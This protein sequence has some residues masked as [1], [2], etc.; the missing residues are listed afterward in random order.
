MSHIKSH[1]YEKKEILYLTCSRKTSFTV[2][3]VKQMD[4]R[5]D[6]MITREDVAKRAGVS[7]SAV[8]RTINKRGYVSSDK[9]EKIWKAID[10]LGYTSNALGKMKTKAKTHQI[11]LLFDQDIRNNFCVE[12][13]EYMMHYAAS[14]GEILFMAKGIASEKLISMSIDG[15]IV[16][17]DDVA[18]KIHKVF[19]EKLK[20]PVVSASYGLPTIQT[21]KIPYVDVDSYDAMR[22]GVEYLRKNGHH[23][24]AYATIRPFVTGEVL[25]PR[26]IAFKNILENEFDTENPEQY[27][28]A[29]WKPGVPR[30]QVSNGRFFEEG[31][32]AA[33]E[34][35][36]K[37]CDATAVIC[38][39]D[40]Y[41][42]GMI[43]RFKQLGYDVPQDI[44]IMGIDGLVE[45]MLNSPRLTSVSMNI[46]KQA[47][48]CIDIVLDLI[49]GKKV[50]GFVSVKPHILE[51]E[52]VK[53]I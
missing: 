28:I 10:E 22:M 32:K 8:S 25:Q 6:N 24:I 37:R 40:D 45:G 51:G 13:Y 3:E 43:S 53:K 1:C 23:K 50:P 20:I 31:M 5:G 39:N 48:V 29:P 15:I 14:R 4:K 17:N 30:I 35:I 27:L 41:A 42:L 44:S 7:V 9:K 12:F 49:D 26:T 16:E 19:G 21:R 18:K 36:I 34:F 38:F 46:K 33:D 2:A 11:C 52:T 47:E